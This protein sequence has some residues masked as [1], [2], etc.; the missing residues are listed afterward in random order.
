MPTL[1]VLNRNGKNVGTVEL[2]EQVFGSTINVPV[3]RRAVL[4]EEANTR[5]GTH[6]TKQRSEVQG[7]GRKP[8]RQ[9]KT[10][11]ARQGTIR[12]PHY[13]HGGV[14]FGPHPR[15]Y[16][17]KVNRQERRL[18]IKSALNA[19]IADGVV[20]VVDEVAFPE[21]KTKSAVEFLR[22]FG[23]DQN[24]VLVIIAE[25]DQNAVKSFRNLPGVTLRAA[26]NFSTRDLLV[27][28]KI[29]VAQAAFKTM[30]E[31]WAK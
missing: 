18:A 29:L 10:G 1:N 4:A 16:G 14:V 11:R 26:P 27:A 2:S 3:M 19:K 15:D 7:G 8:Y 5:Q 12:A 6:N 24:R 9:K 22:S 21:I 28:R 13:A 23:A 31:V 25:H 30:E 20:T 17:M